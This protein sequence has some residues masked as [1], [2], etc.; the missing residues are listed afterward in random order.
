MQDPC[1]NQSN[2]TKLN[3]V[4]LYKSSRITLAKVIYFQGPP[5]CSNGLFTDRVPQIL[6]PELEWRGY[7][8]KESRCHSKNLVRHLDVYHYYHCCHLGLS[9]T[10]RKHID[11][12]S[13][14]E[15]NHVVLSVHTR[16]ELDRCFLSTLVPPL[17]PQMPSRPPLGQS[18]RHS[19]RHYGQQ[20]LLGWRALEEPSM[21]KNR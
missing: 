4:Y 17:P 3:C 20:Q 12:D 5:P 7:Y 10:A 11:R 21:I 2:H 18:L 19:N 16:Y 15:V 9:E 8:G 13:N 1:H 14:L 6:L